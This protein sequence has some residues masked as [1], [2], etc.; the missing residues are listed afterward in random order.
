M[1]KNGKM[2]RNMDCIFT[3]HHPWYDPANEASP[4]SRHAA[5]LVIIRDPVLVE[6]GLWPVLQPPITYLQQDEGT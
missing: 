2:H 4:H 5:W 1:Q 6:G 3:R